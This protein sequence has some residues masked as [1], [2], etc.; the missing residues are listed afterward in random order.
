MSDVLSHTLLQTVLA[1]LLSATI[2]GMVAFVFRYTIA[3]YLKK[4]IPQL[5]SKVPHINFETK[6]KKTKSSEDRQEV[7]GF[8]KT[9]REYEGWYFLRS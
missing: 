2:I 8:V 9:R 7:C 3:A 6:Y 5:T 4:I 1:N